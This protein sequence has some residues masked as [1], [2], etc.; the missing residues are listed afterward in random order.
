MRVEY[1]SAGTQPAREFLQQK[2]GFKGGGQPAGIVIKSSGD[3]A[4]TSEV[5]ENTPTD[6][7]GLLSTI[8][9]LDCTDEKSDK[10]AAKD[11]GTKK[12]GRIEIIS[13]TR[14]RWQN[15]I[16]DKVIQ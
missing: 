9:V 14:I 7:R 13:P 6:K 12:G 10:C 3:F 1:G 4:A 16:L 15:A 5:D 8:G 2:C 11:F